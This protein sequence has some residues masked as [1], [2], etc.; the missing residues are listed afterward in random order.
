VVTVIVPCRNERRYIENC[1]DSILACNY[2]SGGLEILVVDGMSDDGTRTV[3][4][5][6][7][8]RHPVIRMLDNVK[9]TTPCALNIGIKQARGA[10]VMRMD[11]HAQYPPTYIAELV[12]WLERTGADNVGGACVTLPG[13]ATATGRAIA[14]V[15]A[16]R[17]GIGNAHFRLGT[18]ELRTVDT[19][20]FGCFPREVFQRVGLFDEDLVRNQDDEFNLRLV[21]AGGRVLLV[22]G[23]TSR[24]YARGSVRQLAGMFFQYGYFKPLVVRKVG[25][26]MTVRQ[27]IPAVLLLTLTVAGLLAPWLGVARVVLGVTLAGYVTADTAAA[28]SIAR[29]AGLRVGLAASAVFPVLHFAYGLGYLLGVLDFLI[30]GKRPAPAVSLSR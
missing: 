9:R 2:P 16:H 25:G 19:V 10:I 22:P 15:L 12:A 18:A 28:A 20:P 6:Y 23:V 14:A 5:R 3:I 8:G 30:F 29:R 26:I 27:V 21:K 1:L 11:A 4:E 7:A 24:Y 13:D 17:F